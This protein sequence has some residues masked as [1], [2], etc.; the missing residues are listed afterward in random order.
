MTKSL[1]DF[2]RREVPRMR[3]DIMELGYKKRADLSYPPT[4]KGPECKACIAVRK[5]AT[6]AWSKRMYGP[7]NWSK[8]G[9]TM[10]FYEPPPAP[11]CPKHT[12]LLIELE[13]FAKQ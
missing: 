13:Q 7:K 12:A 5:P 8:G 6:D 1:T 4:P 9:K 10:K 2:L 11:T 3:A